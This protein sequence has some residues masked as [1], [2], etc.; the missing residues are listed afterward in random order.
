MTDPAELD[1]DPHVLRPKLTA[2]DLQGAQRGLRR[3]RA[4]GAS[5]RGLRVRRGESVG[6]HATEGRD[7]PA[8]EGGAVDPRLG[9]DRWIGEPRSASS[10][11]RAAQTS[12]LRAPGYTWPRTMFGASPVCVAKRWPISP[13]SESTTTRRSSAA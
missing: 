2:L 6:C 7:G 9:S 1:V 11:S 13:G 8:L 10:W 4:D 5:G 12:P 3:E